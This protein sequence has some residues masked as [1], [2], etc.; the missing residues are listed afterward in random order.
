MRQQV[1]AAVADGGRQRA[2]LI[3][4]QLGGRV[5]GRE[6]RVG[7]PDGA[8]PG[9]PEQVVALGAVQSQRP[10][11][12]LQHL[13]GVFV[14][15][16]R[17]IAARGGQPLVPGRVLRAPGLLPAAGA[18]FLIMV[19]FALHQQAALGFGLSSLYWQRLPQRLH[20]RLPPPA[21]V[22]AA[23]AYL[24][25]GVL[26]ADGADIGLGVEP[27]LTVGGLAVGC[28]YSP[29]FAAA[30]GRVDPAAAADGSGVLVTVI[31]L[32]QVVGVALLGTRFLGRAAQPAPPADSGRALLVTLSA[33]AL[34][35]LPAALFALR[36]R[37]VTAAGR[38]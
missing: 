7:G 23:G 17:R 30:L 6:G 14:V 9:Q 37:R 28:A 4:D 29:L 11:H 16:E 1:L 38:D 5:E 21:L 33:I 10:G 35:L 32:G 24:L 8:E 31:Q 13:L 36:A 2:E 20:R 15:V 22:A 25:F 26:A 3:Q 18:I 27:A 12:R 19:A 34:A